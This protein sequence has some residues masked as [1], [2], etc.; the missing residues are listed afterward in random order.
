MASGWRTK[1]GRLRRPAEAIFDAWRRRGPRDWQRRRVAEPPETQRRSGIGHDE[2]A[3]RSPGSHLSLSVH[4]VPLLLCGCS[5]CRSKCN[6]FF[7]LVCVC[8]AFGFLSLAWVVEGFGFFAVGRPC[9]ISFWPLCLCFLHPP[10]ISALCRHGI[11]ISCSCC[12]LSLVD[13]NYV[14]PC[15]SRQFQPPC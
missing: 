7:Q 2:V 9:Q 3:G 13:P 1:T 14:S 6:M 8:F 4:L 11:W 15:R 10:D 12:S 5:R